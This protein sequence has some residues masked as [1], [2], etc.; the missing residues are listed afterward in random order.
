MNTPGLIP[1][2]HKIGVFRMNKIDDKKEIQLIYSYCANSFNHGDKFGPLFTPKY[3][4]ITIKR[5]TL[6]GAN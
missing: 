4:P 5:T 3:A 6:L 1:P 2:I